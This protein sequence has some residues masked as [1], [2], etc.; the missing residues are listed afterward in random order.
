[1]T[2]LSWKDK[3]KTSF[4]KNPQKAIK[5]KAIKRKEKEQTAVCSFLFVKKEFC[6]RQLFFLTATT[7][8]TIL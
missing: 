7:L 5:N 1:M 8:V 2:E 3:K 6:Q 4:N